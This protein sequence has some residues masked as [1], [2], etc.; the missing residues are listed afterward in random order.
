M[1][2]QKYTSELELQIEAIKAGDGALADVE[3]LGDRPPSIPSLSCP[4]NSLPSKLTTPT[5]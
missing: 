5:R 4:Y 1:W 3:V 2:L